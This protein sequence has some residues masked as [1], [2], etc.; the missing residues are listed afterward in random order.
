MEKIVL[1]SHNPHKIREVRA[2]LAPL[3]IEVLGATDVGVPDVAETGK[4]FAENALIKARHAHQ[5][6]G[7]PALSDDSGLCICALNNAPGLFSARFA[8]QNGGYPAVFEV[9]KHLLRD[10]T[11]KSAFFFCQM[12]LVW[13][14]KEKD[15]ALFEGQIDGTITDYPQGLEGF[16]YDPIFIPQGFGAPIATLPVSIKNTLSHRAKALAAVV[17]FLKT[18]SDLGK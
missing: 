3:K 8:A 4:T 16:G 6:T 12:A 5:A 17:T 7:L 11:D 1:A 13:G 9:I 14:N 2:I 10:K 15:Y 18:H